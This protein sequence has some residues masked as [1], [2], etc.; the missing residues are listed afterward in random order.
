MSKQDKEVDNQDREAEN[1]AKKKV[2]KKKKKKFKFLRGSLKSNRI[3]KD[4]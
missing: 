2:K 4:V 3:A 1:E